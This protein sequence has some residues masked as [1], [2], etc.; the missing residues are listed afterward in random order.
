MDRESRSPYP[1]VE[2]FGSMV[3]KQKSRFGITEALIQ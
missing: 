2:D 3:G 1:R